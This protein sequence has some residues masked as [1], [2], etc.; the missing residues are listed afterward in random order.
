MLEF[1]A[2]IDLD[3]VA[4]FDFVLSMVVVVVRDDVVVHSRDSDIADW[5]GLCVALRAGFDTL[6]DTV[7][8]G[9]GVEEGLFAAE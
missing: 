7:G 1:V 5:E 3:D 4:L 9:V 6:F 8:D 2:V